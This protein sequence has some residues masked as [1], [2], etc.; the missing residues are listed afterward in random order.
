M[1]LPIKNQKV[2]ILKTNRNK[3]HVPYGSGYNAALMNGGGPMFQEC[4][5]IDIKINNLTLVF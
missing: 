1:A 2:E 5:G 4:P 3:R